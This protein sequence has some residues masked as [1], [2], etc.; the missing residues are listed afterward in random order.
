MITERIAQLT[1]ELKFTVDSR[2]LTAFDK[3]LAGVEA[4]LRE[5]SKLTN[6]RFGVK[7][8]L[9]T[10]T[11]R[12]ELAK[13]ATQ[14][15]VLKNI[16]VDAAAVRLIS[17]KLQERLNATPIRLKSVRLDLSGIRDQ[18]NFVKTALGQ[19]KVDLPVE[20]GLAQASRTLYEWKKR[21]ESRFKIHLNADISRSKLLQNARNTLRDVQGRLNGLAVATPQIRLSVD[22]AHLR[23]EIQDVLEQIRREVRIRI[24]LESSIRGG[25]AG[26]SRGTA[27]HIRQGMGMGIGSELAGW[28]RGFIP[29]L[30]GAFAIMQLNR[31]NQELQGQRLA[32]QAVGGGVQG[33]Q[34]LQATLRDISQRL[35][36]DDR[37]LGSS[38]VKMMAAGQA[39]DFSKEQVDSIFQSMA[40]YG[41]VMG[42][43]GEA[44]K[45]SFRAV[46][47]MMGKG[48][49]MSEELKGQLAERFPAAVALMAKSQDMT[50]A[51]LMKTM[52]DGK[53]KSDA[54]IPFARTLA[55]EARKGGALDAAM[56]GTAAQQGRFQ[57]GWNRTIEAFAAGG[58]DRG[59]SDFFKIAAQGMKEAL[60]LVTALG[61]GFEALMRPVNA[62]VGIGG[63]LGS[64]WENIAKQFN[65]TGTGLTL[66]TAQTLAL[67]TPMGRLISSISW[68][69]L[70][71]EDFIV[72]L[73]GGDSVFG[74][75]LNN[76]VQAAET[77]EKLASE[78]SEL[79]NNL[80]GIFSVVPGLAEALKGLEFNEMLVSTMREL[81]A[82]MEFFNSVVERFA[83]AGKYRDAK[84]AEAGGDRSTIMS[85]IDTMYA[86]FNPED[87][88]DKATFIGD[89]LVAQNI[90]AIQTETHTRATQSLT[91]DQFGYMMQRGQVR[92]EMEGAL[93]KSAIDIS[94]NLNVS[95]IDAQGNVMTTEA[96]ERVR[97]IVSNVLEEEISR[98]SASYKESQ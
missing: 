43:D 14:R 91:P 89:R 45:G 44:M 42:L 54:L 50:I 83:I 48:Q 95:G 87:A 81:A 80:D 29:G 5:F 46:E 82:I 86:M 62:L 31:A 75:F 88:K 92:N 10:K 60:P 61:G 12:E 79:K 22:R 85:N 40:E 53:L 78:S 3:K 73:E 18:K 97:E 17:E 33:G 35:G 38:Y 41:R 15:V 49:I 51:E 63:E 2:P 39:S 69:A 56:Q 47:Q 74:D 6:K 37:A 64:Q 71:L 68:G 55:E 84:I 36:L 21:T 65:M 26:G 20:L 67:L 30:G 72:F 16:A 9:D 4:R 94:F 25:G 19:T 28:G 98:A 23:R 7:L 66:T 24:D 1:G 76:N 32:M 93:K 70:A 34:E 59:M 58:F 96:Q 8:T 13:A 77:F 52:E 90:D 11:L 57:F 27:G